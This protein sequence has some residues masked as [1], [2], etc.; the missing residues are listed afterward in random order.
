M[1]SAS[2]QYWQMLGYRSQRS[3]NISDPKTNSF[4][5]PFVEEMSSL[6][7]GLMRE[8]ERRGSTIREQILALFD[9]LGEFFLTEEFRGC[10]FINADCG[11]SSTGRSHT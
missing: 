7:I 10:M 4:W 5:L 9:T 6:G 3:I 2:I 1:W 11:V 8:M